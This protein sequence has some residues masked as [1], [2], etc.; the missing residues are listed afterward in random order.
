MKQGVNKEVEK[1]AE[2][3]VAKESSV[4]TPGETAK[5]RNPFTEMMEEEKKKNEEQQEIF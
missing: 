4:L 3:I 2:A 5:K 1:V